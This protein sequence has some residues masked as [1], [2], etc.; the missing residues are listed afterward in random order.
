MQH[1]ERHDRNLKIDPLWSSMLAFFSLVKFNPLW[2][3]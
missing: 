2:A 1:S 3:H